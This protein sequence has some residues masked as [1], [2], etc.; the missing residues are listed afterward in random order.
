[1]SDKSEMND[2]QSK[3][4]RT[5]KGLETNDF[6]DRFIAEIPVINARNVKVGRLKPIGTHLANDEEIVNSLAD[7][8][9]RFKRFFFTQFEVTGERTKRWLNEVVVKDDTRIL[10]LIVD[11]TNRLTGHVGA[12]SIREDSAELDNFI[13]GT[14]GG[15][16]KLMLLSGLSLIGWLHGVLKIE[17]IHA[18]V[19]ADNFRTLSVYEAAGCFKRSALPE[20]LTGGQTADENAGGL[21]TAA[22]DDQARL[23]EGAEFVR[24]TL[25]MEK[26]LSRYPWMSDLS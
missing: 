21:T 3:I 17:K 19:L 12:C 13:R 20:F 6:G 14:R 24:M 10:F 26:F 1:M 5:L 7:W 22:S 2:G 18:R 23:E 9:R 25:D 16:P 4:I 8:R 11:A 15:D